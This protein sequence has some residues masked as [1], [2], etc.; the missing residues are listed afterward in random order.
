MVTP[1]VK[2]PGAIVTLQDEHRYMNL[3]L[4]TL[5]EQLQTSDLSAPGEYFLMQDIVRYLHEYPDVGF[6]E[7]RC[8]SAT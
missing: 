1:T 2:L 7:R 5:E 3:L 6:R 8:P 4:G